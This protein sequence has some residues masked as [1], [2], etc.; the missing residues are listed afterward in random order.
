MNERRRIVVK[1]VV[2]G[3]GFRPFVYNLATSLGLK[4]YV[5][6]SS[7]GVTIEIEGEPERYDTKEVNRLL[8][9]FKDARKLMQAMTSGKGA[10]GFR[11]ML[12]L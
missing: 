12:G 7:R 2:Q 3:V 10:G 8:N 11:K 6:N 9:Q 4:G 1:G 5:N